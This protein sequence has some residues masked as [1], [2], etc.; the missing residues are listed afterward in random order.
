MIVH[1]DDEFRKKLIATLD[2]EHFAVTYAADGAA[3]LEIM[4]KRRFTVIM[5]GLNI[6]AKKG[7][8]TLDYLREHRES[9]GCG[10]LI[11]GDSDPA[12]R[13]FAPWADE[14]LVKPVDPSYVATRAR[15]YCRC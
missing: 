6:A 12:L 2:Q 15:A 1:D 10:V 5:L 4:K 8:T 7:T 14:T 3:A 9:V 11:L 13:T